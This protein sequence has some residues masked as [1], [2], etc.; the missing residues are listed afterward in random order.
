MAS[1]W[2]SGTD[3]WMKWAISMGSVSEASTKRMPDDRGFRI[4]SCLRYY[5]RLALF[6]LNTTSVWLNRRKLSSSI[7]V[8]IMEELLASKVFRSLLPRS[9]SAVSTMSCIVSRNPEML[10]CATC[11]DSVSIRGGS[12]KRGVLLDPFA[13]G[14]LASSL[15]SQR[16]LSHSSSFLVRITVSFP[17]FKASQ[18]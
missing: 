8:R 14:R 7:P 10:V 18:G 6:G 13:C 2:F 4:R 16:S 5:N 9:Y 1:A 3:A 11:G 15:S 17:S 12:K